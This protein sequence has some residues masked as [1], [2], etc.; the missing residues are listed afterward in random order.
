V[1]LSHL[2]DRNRIIKD[3]YYGLA[4]AVSGPLFSGSPFYDSRIEPY[5][6][7]VE[8]AKKL[9]ANAGWQDHDGDGVLDKNGMPFRFTLIYPNVNTTFQKMLPILKEDMAKAGIQLDILALE[10]SVILERVD[11]RSFDAVAM[12][13][14]SPI[15]HDPYQLWH[16]ESA[17]QEN[18]SNYI[19]FNN[20]EADRLIEEIRQ[21]FD[22][23][24][25][26]ELYHQFHALIHQEEPYLF[27]FSASS[28]NAISKRYRNLREFPLGFSER[29]LWVPKNEQLP[30][31]N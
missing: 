1:A 22:P 7:N 10:W 2:V 31:G 8:T 12:G 20:P 16:S 27:L 28:L 9:L 6:F 13:W 30:A 4:N 24:K 29:I 25:L 26:T 11:S 15:M 5:E 23:E 14:V 18:S 21:C 3:V 17:K 19:N